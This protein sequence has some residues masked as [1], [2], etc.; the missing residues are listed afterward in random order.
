MGMLD[1]KKK[2][3]WILHEREKKKIM[4]KCPDK[5]HCNKGDITSPCKPHEVL[6]ECPKYPK[7]CK[8]GKG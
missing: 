5:K 1:T 8:G 3:I 4:K 2:R 7:Q 6:C